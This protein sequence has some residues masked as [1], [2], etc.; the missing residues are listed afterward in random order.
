MN[1][2][3]PPIA[4]NEDT[5][6]ESN[7]SSVRLPYIFRMARRDGD[8]TNV[9]SQ[10][11]GFVLFGANPAFNDGTLA[12]GET[13][14]LVSS[15]DGT[16]IRG[17]VT[18]IIANPAVGNALIQT[19]VQPSATFTPGAGYVLWDRRENFRFV[20]ELTGFLADGQQNVPLGEVEGTPDRFGKV[21]IDVRDL[22]L[23][24]MQKQ[25]YFMFGNAGKNQKDESCWIKFTATFYATY[26]DSSIRKI[27]I[28]DKQAVTP[29]TDRYWYGIDGVKYLQEKYGQNY[30][31]YLPDLV[32]YP[33]KF[34][35]KF[36][37]PTYF[38]GY[39]FSLSFIYNTKLAGQDIVLRESEKLNN[40]SPVVNIQQLP[41]NNQ[42]PE[43]VHQTIM[44]GNYDPSVNVVDAALIIPDGPSPLRFMEPTYVAAGY[45]GGP[46]PAALPS[47]TIISEWKRVNIN[48]DCRKDPVYLMW[49][50]S[51]GGWDYW[52]FDKL[53]ET[54]ITT[55]QGSLIEGYVDFISSYNTRERLVNVSHVRKI[56]VGDSVD[57]ATIKAF[58]ELESS[59]Q[60]FVLR[61][62]DF[63]QF[64]AHL[65][66]TGIRIAPKGVKYNN[67][68]N[69]F[70]VEVTFLMP[71]TFTLSN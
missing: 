55:A 19:D 8:Y 60:A 13:F 46:P 35:T 33:A 63:T 64:P 25:N 7:W 18:A 4:V 32:G 21:N 9:F 43:G 65:N 23:R 41:I 45:V 50:N 26:Y 20:M 16:T 6:L 62:N 53:T 56:T 31:D 44:A 37:Q 15:V 34:L 36:E 58:A 69:S 68:G 24:A 49:R 11:G 71:E 42:V 28:S 12:V 52:L 61:N 47:D 70:D 57:K 10:P 67:W 54:E 27:V 22:L 14:T 30:A 39:P 48:R 40:D 29:F 5:G 38:I 59:S 2:V 51:V 3:L 66:W 1:T 17:K